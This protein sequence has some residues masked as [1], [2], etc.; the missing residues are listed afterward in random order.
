M[1]QSTMNPLGKT[2]QKHKWKI[3]TYVFGGKLIVF[4]PTW[5]RAVK[6]CNDVGEDK[7]RLEMVSLNRKGEYDH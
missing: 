7:H 4:F 5:K 2:I 6:W 3:K 1:I